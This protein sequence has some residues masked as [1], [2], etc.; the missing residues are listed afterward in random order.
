MENIR[1]IVTERMNNIQ[2]LRLHNLWEDLLPNDLL[3]AIQEELAGFLINQ[4]INPKGSFHYKKWSA[5]MYVDGL[6]V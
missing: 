3:Q 2:T 6:N 1:I 5:C 4:V